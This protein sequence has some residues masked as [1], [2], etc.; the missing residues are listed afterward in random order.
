[1]KANQKNLIFSSF[2]IL[3]IISIFIILFALHKISYLVFVSILT[4]FL[5]CSFNFLLGILSINIG[6]KKKVEIFFKFI[7]GGMVFRMILT[8]LMVFLSLKFLEL[9]QNSFIFSIFFFY[10]FYLIIE[11]LYLNTRKS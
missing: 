3:S 6:L 9:S 5:I 1:M 4:A 2:L 11:I 10:V 7:F 8:L